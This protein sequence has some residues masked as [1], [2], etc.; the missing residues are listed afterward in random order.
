MNH[1]ESSDDSILSALDETGDSVSLGTDSDS[2]TIG[3]SSFVSRQPNSSREDNIVIEYRYIPDYNITNTVHG[4]NAHFQPSFGYP[5]SIP[6]SVNASPHPGIHEPLVSGMHP[7]PP[8]TPITSTLG[9][10]PIN[11][12]PL[13]ELSRTPAHQH[14][15][16]VHLNTLNYEESLRFSG[17]PE[18]FNTP[19]SESNVNNFQNNVQPLVSPARERMQPRLRS[20]GPVDPQPWVQTHTLE[21]KTYTRKKN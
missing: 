1:S 10:T 13:H 6:N 16:S 14:N 21:R 15:S 7:I 9:S 8:V 5:N 17:L 20:Q 18:L 3:S 11:I 2:T 19:E 4:S 12:V